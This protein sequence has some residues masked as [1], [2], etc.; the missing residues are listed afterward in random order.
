MLNKYS[1]IELLNESDESKEYNKT[2]KDLGLKVGKSRKLNP[3][4]A[5]IYTMSIQASYVHYCW[6][7]ETLENLNDYESMEL[8]L[9]IEDWVQPRNDDYIRNFKRY[10]ELLECYEPGDIAVG[11]YMKLDL[12]E[13]LYKYLLGSEDKCVK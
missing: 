12:L 7:R 9:F 4:K 2:I 5:G 6:P 3:V 8:A 13:D 11:A 10:Y 1:F